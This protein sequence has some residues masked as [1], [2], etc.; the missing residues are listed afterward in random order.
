MVMFTGVG[1]ASAA[2]LVTDNF[3]D[4]DAAGWTTTGGTWIVNLADDGRVLRQSSFAAGALARR[5]SL[6]WHDYTVTAEVLPENYNGLPGWAGVVARASSTSN[7]YAL[8]IKSND[9]AAITRTTNGVTQTLAS[10]RITTD[11]GSWYTLSLTV[12][13]TRLSG[14]VNG[15]TLSATDGFLTGGPAGLT[16]TWTNASFDEVVVAD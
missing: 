14:S 16:T 10:V 3:D 8:V 7:Y 11:A 13:G 1:T 6:A 4:G 5:G 15:T 12:D 2:T 9:T